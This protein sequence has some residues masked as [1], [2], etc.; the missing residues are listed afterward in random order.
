MDCAAR[1]HQPPAH[2]CHMES[3]S[4]EIHGRPQQTPMDH[5]ARPVGTGIN[6]AGTSAYRVTPL[7][8]FIPG[9]TCQPLQNQALNGADDAV[10]TSILPFSAA[11]RQH[12]LAVSAVQ[13]HCILEQV[14]RHG[15]ETQRTPLQKTDH[16]S[17]LANS[18]CQLP[19][20]K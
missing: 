12:A 6:P 8:N 9:N 19:K 10:Q 14:G 17:T 4:N 18:G 7:Y 15:N 11:L 20:N 5:G 2:M 3:P 13:G 16:Q 1:I